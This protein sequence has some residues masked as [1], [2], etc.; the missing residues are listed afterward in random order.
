MQ[1]SMAAL[2]Q[3]IQTLVDATLLEILPARQAEFDDRFRRDGDMAY[4]ALNK[5][6]FQPVRRFLSRAEL[7]AKPSLP[8]DFQESREWGNADETHQQ[9]WMW[10]LI[11]NAEGTTIGAIAVGAHHDHSRFRLPRSPEVI[12]LEA[13][14]WDDAER[15]LEG[16]FP[17]FAKEASFRVWYQNYL[18]QP[19]TADTSGAA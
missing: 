5:E 9:R 11:L 16:R 14:S 8:G 2:S 18:S 10:S 4:G 3:T 12:G 1:Y 6:L 17:A 19:G 13:T 7:T 15:A